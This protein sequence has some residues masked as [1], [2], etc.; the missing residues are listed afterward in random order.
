[1]NPLTDFINSIDANSED[2]IDHEELSNII[3]SIN[4]RENIIL[5]EEIDVNFENNL[6]N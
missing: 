6:E 2:L 3:R 1:M 4:R 5:I